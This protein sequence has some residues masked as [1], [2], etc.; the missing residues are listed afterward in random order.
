MK[1]LL[2][3][4]ALI[5]LGFVDHEFHSRLVGWLSAIETPQLLTCSMTELGFVR[6]LAQI[7]DSGYT[8]AHARDHLLRL[9]ANSRLP[10]LFVHDTNDISALPKWVRAP[11]QVADGHLLELARAHDARLATL[12]ARIPGAFLIP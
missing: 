4:N 6:V 9:K 7:R 1:F 8:V 12:D 2:D 11:K 3:V 10:M 5:A